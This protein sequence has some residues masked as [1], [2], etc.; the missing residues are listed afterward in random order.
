M[1]GAE[2]ERDDLELKL[3]EKVRCSIR[4]LFVLCCR[5]TLSHCWHEINNITVNLTA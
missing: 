2:K 5:K 4:L 3:A 1:K